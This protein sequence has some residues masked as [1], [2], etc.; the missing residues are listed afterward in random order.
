[1]I[2]TMDMA[3]FTLM[4]AAA[5]GTYKIKAEADLKQAEIRRIEK[6]IAYEEDT[7]DLLQAD[8]S[9]L[10]Q[11]DRLQKLAEKHAGELAL[12]PIEARQ[13]VDPSDIPQKGEAPEDDDII[14]ETIAKLAKR[15]AEKPAAEPETDDTETGSVEE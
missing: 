10:T 1:M 13:V 9:L 15:K 4:I 12:E 3:L 6:Q 14:G 8:W 11:P 7:I 2:R 5:A